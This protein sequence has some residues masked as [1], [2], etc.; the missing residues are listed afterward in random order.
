MGLSH[1]VL[2]PKMG[3]W[4]WHLEWGGPGT[5]GF[6]QPCLFNREHAGSGSARMGAGCL[7]VSWARGGGGPAGEGDAL[8]GA[9]QCAEVHRGAVQGEEAQLHHRVHQGRHFEEPHQEHGECWGGRSAP[10]GSPLLSPLLWQIPSPAPRTATTP[11]ASG[12]ASPRTSLLAWWVLPG[13]GWG[14]GCW[15]VGDCGVGVPP[16]LSP[17]FPQAYLHSMNIIHRDLNSHNCLVREVSP[18]SVVSALARVGVSA[19]RVAPSRLSI[20]PEQERGGG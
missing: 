20:H 8:P 16:A 14:D 12:S 18:T 7:R 5:T 1:P 11:G 19:P 3:S 9:P 17:S 15:W 4:A 2:R 13:D 6:R 10:V